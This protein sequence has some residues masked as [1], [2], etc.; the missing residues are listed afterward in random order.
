MPLLLWPLSFVVWLDSPSVL[1]VANNWPVSAALML[2]VV[3][4][5]DSFLSGA[6]SVWQTIP[7]IAWVVVTIGVLSE[8]IYA[9]NS[10]YL[11]GLMFFIHSFRSSSLLW[12]GDSS[13]WLWPAWIR[14]STMAVLLFLLTLLPS[15]I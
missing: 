6:K 1:T 5:V 15:S 14:D 7:H 8:V 10:G 13:W 12:Q 2:L 9:S 3:T 4:A 11:L